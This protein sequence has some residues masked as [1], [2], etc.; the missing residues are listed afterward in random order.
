MKAQERERET[1]ILTTY[2]EKKRYVEEVFSMLSESYQNVEGGLLYRSGEELLSKQNNVW[3][4]L[5]NSDS[6]RPQV[7]IIWKDTEFGRKMTACGCT[8][9]K[10]SKQMLLEE[11]HRDLERGNIWAEVSDKIEHW[12]NR[13]DVPRL[14]FRV[15]QEL[16]KDK[17]LIPLGD[18]YHYTREIQG[19]RKQKI[20]FGKINEKAYRQRKSDSRVGKDS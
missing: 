8:Q 16:L 6:E 17:H 3:K 10:V 7:I 13:C 15:A 14:P 5:F 4:L 19:F 11:L 2:R 12:L 1:R 20:I 9:T 18:G